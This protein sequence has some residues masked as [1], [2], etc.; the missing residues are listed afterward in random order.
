VEGFQFIENS[1]H[2]GR[3]R[4]KNVYFMRLNGPF[5]RTEMQAIHSDIE[6]LLADYETIVIIAFFDALAKPPPKEIRTEISAFQ[7]RIRRRVAI[8]VGVV[9]DSPMML[10]VAMMVW[11][12]F[13]FIDQ[14]QMPQKFV[15][16]T[17]LA[18]D[19]VRFD[20]QC[21]RDELA[22][23]FRLAHATLPP[24]AVTATTSVA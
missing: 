6:N 19:L 17:Q 14:R 11:S 4:Y 24:P 16:T 8:Y 22:E 23:A 10:A 21:T 9:E 13:S 18:I 12:A 3:S 15:R 1:G 5:N 2:C 20:V 7:T